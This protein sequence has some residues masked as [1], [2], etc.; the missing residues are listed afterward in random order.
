MKRRGFWEVRSKDAPEKWRFSVDVARAWEEAVDAAHTPHT[1]KVKLRSAMIMSPDP[2]G[3]F[4]TLLRL[5]RLGLG[6]KAGSGRQY[7]SWIH[8]ADFV[9][10]LEW[11]IA[12]DIDGPVNLSSPQPLPYAEFMRI[13]RNAWGVPVGLPATKWMLDVGTF[14]LRTETELV[15]KSRRVVPGRLEE[16]G[17]SFQYPKWSEAAK[18][19]CNRRREGGADGSSGSH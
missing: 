7:V 16:S 18:E 4:D 11:L 15:L 19:L 14:L 9:R 3:I 5:V 2:G 13:L 10:A 6:G 8:E 12:H 17:F 1:R